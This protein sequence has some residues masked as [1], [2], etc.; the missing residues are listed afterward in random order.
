MA[1]EAR[2][3]LQKIVLDHRYQKYSLFALTGV[4]VFEYGLKEGTM[5]H[6]FPLK[7]RDAVM[8]GQSSQTGCSR[9]SLSLLS[10]SVWFSVPSSRSP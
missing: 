2:P 5:F 8:L 3:V 7:P 10:I 6:W 9:S 1:M 4:I